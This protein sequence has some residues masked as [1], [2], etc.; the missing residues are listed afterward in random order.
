MTNEIN[1]T[2]EKVANGKTEFFP[3]GLGSPQGIKKIYND[4]LNMSENCLKKAEICTSNVVSNVNE[5]NTDAPKAAQ[6]SICHEPFKLIYED[7]CTHVEIPTIMCQGEENKYS[8]RIYFC[9]TIINRYKNK[10]R[11]NCINKINNLKL[12]LKNKLKEANL[13]NRRVFLNNIKN[14]EDILNYNFRSIKYNTNKNDVPLFYEH[15]NFVGHIP[16]VKN[17][18]HELKIAEMNRNIKQSTAMNSDNIPFIANNSF[19]E[20][21]PNQCSNE[22]T[23]ENYNIDNIYQGVKDATKKKQ[24]NKSNEKNFNKP[25]NK[26]D[27]LKQFSMYSKLNEIKCVEEPGMTYKCVYPPNT[28]INDDI[29]C[30]HNGDSSKGVQIENFQIV[31]NSKFE[32]GNLQYVLKEKN[33]EYYS[34]FINSDIRMNKKTN[35]W[36]YFSA[37]YMPDEYYTKELKKEKEKRQTC[38]SEFLNDINK[39]TNCY[40]VKYSVDFSDKFLVSNIKKLKKPVSVIFRIENMSKPHFL[41]KEGYSPLVFSECKNKFENIQWE[42]NAYNIKYIK[43][44]KSRYFNTKKN[45]IEK[46]SYT[47]YTL[48]FSYDF[49]YTCD[50]VYFSS[51]Y[52]YTYSYLMEY[53]SSIKSY[54]KK[55]RP[56]INY[57]E[58]TLCK[59]TCGLNCPIL[60]ITNYDKLY[61]TSKENKEN[62]KSHPELDDN[63]MNTTLDGINLSKYNNKCFNFTNSDT[64]DSCNA[65]STYNDKLWM[66][67]LL[68]FSSELNNETKADTNF[69][70]VNDLNICK[71]SNNFMSEFSNL[72]KKKI[73]LK[74]GRSKKNEEKMVMPCLRGASLLV[75]SNKLENNSKE[76]TKEIIFLT[77]RVHP[78]ETNA[79][80]AMHGFLSFIISNNIYA[81]ILR[82]NYIFIIIPML[83]IDGVIL[84]HNR[85]C[86]NGF[87]LNRQWDKPIYY[88]HPTIYTAKSLLKNLQKN[89]NKIIFYCDFHGHSSKYNCFLFGNSGTRTFLKKRNYTEHFANIIYQSI[90]WFSLEDTKFKNL[91]DSEGKG[92]TARYICGTELKIDCSYTL[93]LSLLGVRVGRSLDRLSNIK[94]DT[95]VDNFGKSADIINDSKD[96]EYVDTLCSPSKGIET[97]PNAKIIVKGSST[98]CYTN[99]AKVSRKETEKNA[100]E[101]EDPEKCQI[102]SCMSNKSKLQGNNENDSNKDNFIFFNEN[103]LL[104]TGV[105]FGIC[106]FKFMN[107]FSHCKIYKKMD[108]LEG[109]PFPILSNSLDDMCGDSLQITE[110]F[111]DLGG[112]LNNMNKSGNI[113]ENGIIIKKKKLNKNYRLK[114]NSCTYN[115]ENIINNKNSLQYAASDGCNNAKKV[116]K[117]YAK[118]NENKNSI[119]GRMF[120]DSSISCVHVSNNYGD[121]PVIGTSHKSISLDKKLIKNFEVMQGNNLNDKNWGKGILAS[122]NEKDKKKKIVI[123]IKKVRSN[124]KNKLVTKMKKNWHNNGGRNNDNNEGTKECY[125]TKTGSKKRLL[126]GES[127]NDKNIL[128]IN[129]LINLDIFPIISSC[130]NSNIVSKQQNNN[131]TKLDFI[132]NV[133][134]KKYISN[135]YINTKYAIKRKRKIRVCRKKGISFSSNSKEPTCMDII[136]DIIKRA[137]LQNEGYKILE[138]KKNIA[139]DKSR[140]N[141]NKKKVERGRKKKKKRKKKNTK[142]MK[143]IT[144][145]SN[146]HTK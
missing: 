114:I 72:L 74:M 128:K 112:K 49:M 11:K 109:E 59:T 119:V 27:E 54:V 90:P 92:G 108:E 23:S 83:N 94:N 140:D 139:C 107:L 15:D 101:F 8:S 18:L 91:N 48:E 126:K 78:G 22:K 65:I 14:I 4:N 31:F 52:P 68:P 75:S 29:K 34:L 145:L 121:K 96:A 13:K 99:K 46:L 20:N 69:D 42:R 44:N 70:G 36:F 39:E 3:N 28:K 53:L 123:K 43:N 56:D 142:S 84:G 89:N 106:L 134:Y 62:K 105:S 45:C 57:I 127:E 51:C 66:Y 24:I 26:S 88:L 82:T 131:S 130:N 47:T 19:A 80:Y 61:K 125:T 76:I 111:Q 9:T 1:A 93:E 33:K 40:H 58:E 21:I 98:R 110:N 5:S 113:E 12:F 55:S 41:Y 117:G 146:W 143:Y 132:S 73:I 95:P 115:I 118:N 87:D 63:I 122:S 77:C 100:S 17:K 64:F 85:F 50:T 67:D 35:Q 120:G 135:K 30:R 124:N 60:V 129:E 86:S 81:N 38:M 137:D 2:K 6:D 141:H 71:L 103:L 133:Y 104:V 16:I 10:D 97:T 138:N 136:K 144:V 116:V 102:K 37:S 7:S 25:S 32:S 79:S